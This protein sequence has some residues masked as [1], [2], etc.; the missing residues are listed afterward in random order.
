MGDGSRAG[1]PQGGGGWRGAGECRWRP[2]EEGRHPGVCRKQRTL[3]LYEPSDTFLPS[4]SWGWRTR[5]VGIGGRACRRSPAHPRLPH[6]PVPR[7]QR[8][9]PATPI[10]ALIAQSQAQGPHL[11]L[12]GVEALGVSALGLQEAQERV[13]R[14]HTAAGTRSTECHARTRSRGLGGEHGAGFVWWGLERSL[15]GVYGS[16]GCLR[17]WRSV[18]E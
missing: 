16:D 3:P 9:H 1:R 5:M 2:G 6:R 18:I 14:N 13:A 15:Q 17:R 4:M 10:V 8:G 7:A 11:D 12:E